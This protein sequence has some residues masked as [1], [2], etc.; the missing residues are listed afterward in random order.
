MGKNEMYSNLAA[1]IGVEKLKEKEK[2]GSKMASILQVVF[3]SLICF[4]SVTTM[5]FA[6]EISVKIFDNYFGTGNGVGVAIENGYIEKSDAEEVSAESTV[7]NEVTG[8][9]L[10][11]VDTKIKVDEFV[12]DDFT[13]SITFDVTLSDDINEVLESGKVGDMNFPDMVIYDENN[14]VLYTMVSKGLEEFCK[15]KNLNI[16]DYNL[17]SDKL[18]NSGVNNYVKERNGNHIKVLYNIYTGGDT[19]PKSKK[20]NIYMNEIRISENVESMMGEEEILLQGK[21][22]F[23][24]DVPEKMYNRKN[25]IYKQISSTDKEFKVTKAVLYDT[26]MDIGLNFPAEK[27]ENKLFT[28]PELEFYYSL[29]D[30]DE[31]KN[32]EIGAYLNNLCENTDEYWESMEKRMNAFEFEKYITNESGEKFELTVGPRENGGAHISEEGIMDFNGMFDVT[33]YNASD[34]LVLHVNYHGR[35]ADI[36][37][38]K[39]EE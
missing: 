24:V 30:D 33:K 17:E 23:S 12:M 11:G 19:Y 10:S 39:V 36:T 16:K 35:E 8:K 29:E 4:T 27:I 14:I 9:K 21:W 2:N 22:D 32:E 38:E 3:A 26:G 6:K 13:L 1:S 5:V 7:E 18:V 25:V 15:D 20:L 37:F 34:K 31:I 28:T